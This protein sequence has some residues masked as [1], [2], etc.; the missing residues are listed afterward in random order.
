MKN[1][2]EKIANAYGEKHV[3]RQ[4]CFGNGVNFQGLRLP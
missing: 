3:V 1:K 2:V 4:E